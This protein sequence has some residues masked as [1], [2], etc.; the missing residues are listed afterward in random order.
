MESNPPFQSY[1]NQTLTALYEPRYE[2]ECIR[3]CET[4]SITRKGMAGD[5]RR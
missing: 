4:E 2:T 5:Q 1:L 3:E